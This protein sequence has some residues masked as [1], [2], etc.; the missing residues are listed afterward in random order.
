MVTVTSRKRGKDSMLQEISRLL[1]S[2]CLLGFMGFL[3]FHGFSSPDAAEK[4]GC[5]NLAS[6]TIG[7][8]TTYWLKPVT[9]AAKK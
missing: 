2:L 3:Y 4:L 5:T 8:V 6:V 7:A 1:I 9:P